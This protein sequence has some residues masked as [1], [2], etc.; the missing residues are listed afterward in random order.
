MVMDD[1]YSDFIKGLTIG[2]G[3]REKIAN[4]PATPLNDAHPG[5]YFYVR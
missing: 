4:T 1:K 2:G 5:G 3:M